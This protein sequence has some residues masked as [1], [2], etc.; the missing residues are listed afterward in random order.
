LRITDLRR[1]EVAGGA[2]VAARLIWEDADRPSQDVW[3]ECRGGAPTPDALGPAAELSPNPDA[4]LL[5]SVMPALE[6][7]E[8]RVLVEGAICPELRGGVLTAIGVIRD[9]F[10]GLDAP[11]I[12][13]SGGYRVPYPRE[14]PRV[15]CFMS[16]G[17]DALAT[18]LSNRLIYPLDHPASV[19]DG[20]YLFGMNSHDFDPKDPP[21][22]NAARLADWE[23]R[24]QRMDALAR[25]MQIRLIPVITNVRFVAGDF[26]FWLRRGL[27]AG[28][29]SVAHAFTS[30]LTRALIGS[31]GI[32]GKTR[33]LGTHPLLDPLYSS[34]AL[35]I[36]H[37]G[38][39]LS[40]FEK[41]AL[42][43][44]SA[45]AL[46]V[47]QCCQKHELFEGV[48]CGRCN[49]CVRTMVHLEALG[50]LGDNTVF[51]R[52]SI[53]ADDILAAD[54]GDEP[55][56]VFLEQAVE[57]LEQRGRRDLVEAIRERVAQYRSLVA[58]AR[59]QRSLLGLLRV[60][61]RPTR[62]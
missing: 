40:R 20:L 13:A 7:G 16:A 50:K 49:K 12:E 38:N 54:V 11:A 34:A 29:A 44:K 22:P 35:E 61:A 14:P 41:T 59:R 6:L 39:W 58:R 52:T 33:P 32:P 17:V 2:R 56:V 46:S 30:R 8:R 28:L 53:T 51:P 62:S 60:G 5:A 3:F 45:A 15:A 1:E 23:Q 31:S 55:D 21:S 43:A 27:G 10:P 9:W 4:F 36:V 19:R 48:N 37:H 18:L 26:T 25:E 57:R 42:I 24:L 47:L